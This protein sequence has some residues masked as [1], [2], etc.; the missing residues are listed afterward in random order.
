MVTQVWQ[1][2]L[3]KY[4]FKLYWSEIMYSYA[5]HLLVFEFIKSGIRWPQA[6]APG[7]LKLLWFVHQCLFAHARARVCVCLHVYV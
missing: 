1:F 6:G 7:L 3:A 4:F 5:L 2:Y